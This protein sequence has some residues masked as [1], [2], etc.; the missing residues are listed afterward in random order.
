[1]AQESPVFNKKQIFA[2]LGAIATFLIILALPTPEALDTPDGAVELTSAGK[3]AL[4]TLAFCVILWATE[5]IPFAVTGLAGIV[6]LVVAKVENLDTLVK[7]GF[8]NTIIVFFLGVLLFS[9]AISETNLLKRVTTF[10]LYHLG[11][12]PKAIVATFLVLGA[13]LSG[14]ITDM[15]VAAMFLPIGVSVLKDAKVEPLKSNFGRAVMIA[16][17]WG[18]LIGGV[19]TPAGCGPNP[20]T[21]GFLKDLADIDFT[22]RDWILIGY[23]A[24]LLMLPLGWW[25][26]I[27]VFPIED[28]NLSIA[29]EDFKKRLQELGPLD[30]KEI[31]TLIIFA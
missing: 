10:M 17:S 23:P 21:I 30:R 3:A 29:S 14:W 1:M 4:A 24:T 5:A 8:G 25:V 19:A 9:A 12:R 11:N 26:L 15:A 20:L 6:L 27:K 22:F 18:P 2:F 7:W 13:L 31:F 16:C 28:V